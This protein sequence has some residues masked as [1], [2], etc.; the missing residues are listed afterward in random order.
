MIFYII[1]MD[2]LF[3]KFLRRLFD[4]GALGLGLSNV[5]SNV[6]EFISAED[7]PPLW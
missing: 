2:Q 4:F 6:S 7:L 5:L 3:K 1:L